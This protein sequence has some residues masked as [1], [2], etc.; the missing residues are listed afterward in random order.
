VKELVRSDAYISHFE[1]GV[2]EELP[3]RSWRALID[4]LDA[5]GLNPR[6]L[7]LTSLKGSWLA[8]ELN[9]PELEHQ[10]LARADF[11]LDDAL[12]RGLTKGEPGLLIYLLGEINRRRGEFLRAKEMLTFQ[13][14]NPRYRYP[15]LLLTV[16]IEEEDSTP[17]WSLHAP[18]RMEDQSPRFKGLFP[19]LRSIPPGKTEFSPTE[20]AESAQE[21]D[22]D[23][24]RSY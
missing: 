16:L 10:L 15:A 11:Y 24:R 20:L 23:D 1:D 7:G 22:E 18:D 5:K 9:N 12:R 8:R 4:I 17:Y 19:P 21:P 6:D 3:V 2:P 14:N 13:G